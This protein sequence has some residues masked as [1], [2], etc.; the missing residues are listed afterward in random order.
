MITK[1]KVLQE[2]KRVIDPE[3]NVNIVDLGLIYDIRV[4]QKIG[5][6][7][8]VMTLTSPGC[9]LSFVFEEWIP[10]AVKKVKDVKDVQLEVVWTPRWTS[11]RL[12]DEVKEQLGVIK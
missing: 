4:N 8:I 5:Q 6:V 12:S 2:L 10:A 11:E 3:L 9:P 1:E 7:L